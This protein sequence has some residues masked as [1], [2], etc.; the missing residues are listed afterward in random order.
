LNDPLGQ[1]QVPTTQAKLEVNRELAV[2]L[3]AAE[4]QVFTARFVRQCGGPVERADQFL[5]LSGTH[6]ARI[7][8]ADDRP[9]A[10]ASD[11]IDG[12]TLPF[13][14]FENAN[15]RRAARATAT[16]NQ[17]NARTIPGRFS[18]CIH[19]PCIRREYEQQDD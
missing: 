6:T 18:C 5:E 7:E 15:V 8:T 11:N 16:Q 1:H 17:A 14:L 4:T 2:I 10:G 3:F 12:D 9:H 19:C 13:Q